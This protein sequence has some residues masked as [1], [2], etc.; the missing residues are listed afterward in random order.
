MD[1][2]QILV[3]FV[4]GRMPFAEFHDLV[5]NDDL[6][7]A[8]IDQHVPSDWKCYTK[9]TP[10]NNYTVQELPFSIRH[11]FEKFAGGDA[12]SSIGYRLDV[13]STMTNLAKTL[14]PTMSIKPDP[15]FKKLFGLL[16]RACPSYIDGNDVW[17]S[18]ILEAFAAECPDEWSDTK[19]I[20]HI[21]ARIIEEFHLEDKKY[22]RWWQNPDWPF[23]NGKPM[24]YV[25][26]TVKYKNEWYQHHFVDLETGEERIVDDMT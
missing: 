23:A 3:D 18:G 19:K 15:S 10:E 24:K 25:K 4:E 11:K 1:Y 5:L 8:W 21:K 16:L 26:T 13:H 7:A 17:D 2:K 6:F 20:K 22:P 14:Y 9:A 12:I